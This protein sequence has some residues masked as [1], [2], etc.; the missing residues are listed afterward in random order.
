MPLKEFLDGVKEI[1]GTERYWILPTVFWLN[2][3]DGFLKFLCLAG[4]GLSL[5]VVGRIFVV[6]ALILLWLFYLS[7]MTAAQE[8]MSFQWDTLLLEAGFLAIFLAPSGGRKQV[9][10]PPSPVWCYFYTDFYYSA[11]SFY[12]EWQNW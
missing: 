3:S 5:C 9:E 7:L 2:A 11:S 6:P 10:P 12:R 8:F 4:A 1:T